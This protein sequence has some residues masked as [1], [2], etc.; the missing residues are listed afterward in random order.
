VGVPDATKAAAIAC[1]NAYA[2]AAYA[3]TRLQSHSL[4]A[5]ALKPDAAIE[6]VWKTRPVAH[7]SET[8]E[9]KALVA[10]GAKLLGEITF[11]IV[12]PEQ[13]VTHVE[14][15][16]RQSNGN[17]HVYYLTNRA[18]GSR[19]IDSPII[20]K[21]AIFSSGIGGVSGIVPL[22]WILKKRQLKKS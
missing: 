7:R 12:V 15:Y 16:Y 11:E 8:C 10:A 22:N 9:T 19:S 4:R 14:G 6:V 17:W 3:I 2:D 13:G 1:D 21:Q 5:R 18:G 20:E